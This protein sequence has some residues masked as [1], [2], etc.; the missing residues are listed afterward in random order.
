MKRPVETRWKTK[1]DASQQIN[2]I[3][4][5]SQRLTKINKIINQCEF[6]RLDSNEI[7][8]INE[9]WEVMKP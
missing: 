2:N 5:S 7:Q 9:Y 3:L 4:K 6:F 1:F 8:L